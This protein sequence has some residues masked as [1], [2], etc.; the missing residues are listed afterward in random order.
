MVDLISVRAVEAL[1]D[2]H[3]LARRQRD[4]IFAGNA[5]RANPRVDPSTIPLPSRSLE[6]R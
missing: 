3:A 2:A 4:A 5:L 1:C 6:T